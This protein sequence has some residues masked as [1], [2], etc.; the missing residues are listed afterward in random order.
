MTAPSDDR[1]MSSIQAVQVSF[2]CYFAAL[3]AI[4]RLLASDISFLFADNAQK[5]LQRA[6][7]K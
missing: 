5:R 2:F 1:T 7:W 3:E 4:S 6:P